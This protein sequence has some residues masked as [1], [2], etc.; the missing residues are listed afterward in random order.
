MTRDRECIMRKRNIG[1]AGIIA[2]A[3]LMLLSSCGGARTYRD[4]TYEGQSEIFV[5]ED[6]TDEGN[7]YGVVSLTIRDGLIDACTYQ[8][9]EPDGTLK[10]ENYGMANG[11][12]ANQ[13]FFNKAQKAVAACDEYAKQLIATGD[14]SSVDVISGATIN[15]DEFVEAVE[16]ALDQAAE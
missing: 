8:T 12:V 10:D 7:G 11:A 2:A 1:K 5:N 13:D 14:I 4:G 6:G 15:Y 9:F 16:D 3:A